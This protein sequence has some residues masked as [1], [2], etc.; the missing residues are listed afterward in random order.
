EA[1]QVVVEEHLGLLLAEGGLGEGAEEA[2]QPL[3]VGA[4]GAVRRPG[5]QLGTDQQIDGNVLAGLEAL[6]QGAA[7]GLEGIDPGAAGEAVAAEGG[8]VEASLPAVVA[9]GRH[10]ETVPGGGPLLAV[11]QDGADLVVAVGEDV[12]LDGDGVAGGA[13]GG[14]AAG[15]DFGLDVLDDDPRP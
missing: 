15:L 10:G 7:P 3:G 13:L 1:E 5:D 4:G 11:E 6:A 12:G 9:Q 14:E 8:Y 2:V